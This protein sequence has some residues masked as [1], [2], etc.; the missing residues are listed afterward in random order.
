MSIERRTGIIKKI[1]I[2]V[3]KRRRKI[4]ETK[5]ILTQ[6]LQNR[7]TSTNQQKRKRFLPI[8]CIP[9]IETETAT[10][11]PTKIKEGNKPT[12][13]PIQKRKGGRSRGL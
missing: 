8:Y 6:I 12:Q 4:T 9:V 3:I 2:I 7:Q 11:S 10:K 13:I 1:I 5:I